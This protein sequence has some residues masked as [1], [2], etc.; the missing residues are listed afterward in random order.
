MKKIIFNL[1]MALTVHLVHSRGCLH[2]VD[3]SIPTILTQWQWNFPEE[4]IYFPTLSTKKYSFTNT[5]I[6][7]FPLFKTFDLQD[8][9]ENY[10]PSGT[11]LYR[12]TAASL[13]GSEFEKLLQNFFK[14]VLQKKDTYTD[15]TILKDDDFNHKKHVGLLIVQCKNHPFVVKLFMETPRSF[16][17]PHN[18][19]II[20]ILQ[21]GVGGGVTRHLSGFTRIKNS[22]TIRNLLSKDPEWATTVDIP[23]KWYWIPHYPWIQITTKNLGQ[24]GEIKTITLPGAYAIVADYINPK[25][26][27]AITSP[28]DREKALRLSNYVECRVDPHINNF[29]IEKDTNKLVI[30]DTEHFPT[31][32]GLRKPFFL[33]SYHRFYIDLS[34]KYLKEHVFSLKRDRIERRTSGYQPFCT[35]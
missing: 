26:I 32:T 15:F 14:E 3:Q 29:L 16:M 4:R 28:E 11:I 13:E 20:P 27:F 12:N 5:T 21:F 22:K 6:T 18:K 30:I 9:K 8:L 7:E 10:L 24:P 25:K 31:L 34:K 19:G 17:R 2:F 33:T 35:A 1:L 23:R